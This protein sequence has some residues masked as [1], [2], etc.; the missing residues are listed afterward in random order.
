MHIRWL[1]SNPLNGGLEGPMQARIGTL[2]GIV[3]I[4]DIVKNS[5]HTEIRID[6]TSVYSISEY[7]YLETNGFSINM[8]KFCMG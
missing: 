7:V 5:N 4:L 2:F 6:Q 3:H 1:P 8:I